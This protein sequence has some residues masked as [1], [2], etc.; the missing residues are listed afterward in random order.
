MLGGEIVKVLGIVCSPRLRGN[1]EI[2]VR[3][4]LAKAQEAGAEVELVTLAGKTI[5]PCDGCHSCF[6]TKECRIKDDMQ[7]IYPK[8]L[9]AD[10]IILGTPVYFWSVSAQAKA[11]MD[12][13]YVLYG[14]TEVS[15][16]RRLRNK[17]AGAVVTTGRE[18]GTSALSVFSGFFTLQR[19]IMVGGAMG[20][21][22]R[23][24]GKIRQDERVMA[25]AAAL[26]RAIVRRIQS[27]RTQ[28]K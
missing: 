23:E 12:R 11:L 3:E 28:A 26:G 8:L 4:S 5:A 16:E 27:L 21:G 6:E 1:T 10:G 25:E 13:T 7:D 19:M 2:L 24:K 20:L 15:A 14:R 9:A 22:G 17:V 18:G